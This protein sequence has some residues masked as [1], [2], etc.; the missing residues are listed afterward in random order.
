MTVKE[1]MSELEKLGSESTKKTFINHGA[2]ANVFGVKVGD[3]KKIQKKIKKNYELSLQL[4]DTGNSDAM[5]LAGLIADEKKMTKKDLQKW[6]ENAPWNM[7]SEY[8]VPWIAA[9]SNYGW[10]LATEWIDSK[11][12]NIAT[13]G[14]ATLSSYVSITPDEKLDI[15]SLDKLLD[16]VKKE[17]HKAPNRV[18]YVMNGFVISVGCYVAAL[19]AKAKQTGKDI[20]KVHVEMGGTACKVPEAPA[21][22]DK[23]V[24]AGRLGRKRKEA[25]C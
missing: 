18:R 6:V 24:K 19:T 14:W 13:S 17:I 4:Y 1:I 11:K 22:I 9:E 3:L 16:R 15:K 10:E 23:V 2:N 20:G 25:R 12:D 8:T 21:Y 5:Y 7:I